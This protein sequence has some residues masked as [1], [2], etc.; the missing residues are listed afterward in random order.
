VLPNVIEVAAPNNVAVVT[1]PNAVKEPDVPVIDVAFGK[2]MV[3]EA[4]VAV[5]VEIPT[6]TLT[7]PVPVPPVAMLTVLALVPLLPVA[8]FIV[9]V[10]VV[11]KMV[12]VVTSPN[13]VNEPDVP[14]ILVAFGNAIVVFDV[15]ATPV[16]LPN[17]NAVAEVNADAVVAVAV[18][19]KATVVAPLEAIVNV[20]EATPML[21]VVTAPKA[22][23]AVTF[24]SNSVNVPVVDAAIVAALAAN[25]VVVE[26]MVRV[27]VPEVVPIIIAVVPVP[28]PPVPIFIVLVAPAT[29]P[30]PMFKVTAPVGVVLKL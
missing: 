6:T 1:A 30:V 9:E 17:V 10:A 23:I 18:L 4:V 20:P 11:P 19:N 3:A 24:A 22:F 2:A 29:A 15:V 21:R 26:F 25:V 5:P 7:V 14:V 16:E 28:L 27:L 13:A 12:A 8:M